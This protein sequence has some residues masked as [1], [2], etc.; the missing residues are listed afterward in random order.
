MTTQGFGL[1]TWDEQTQ[2]PQQSRQNDTKRL[3]FVKLE[4]GNNILRIITAPAKYWFAK[5]DDGKS[6]YGRRVRCAFP[7]VPRNECPTVMAG[8]KPKKRYYAGVIQRNASGDDEVKIFDMSVVVYEKLQSFNS[9]PEYG[10]PDLFDINVRYNPESSTPTDFYSVIPRSK[11]PLSEADLALINSVG[12][13]F[14]NE[15]L[16]HLS[17]PH[18]VERVEQSLIKLGWDGTVKVQSISK[19]ETK[20]EEKDELDT[21][22]DYSFENPVAV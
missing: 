8:A 19:T 20:S 10:T 12:I 9:D 14:I 3:D 6:P 5:Y 1:T 11:K 15:Q 18:S 7:A 2:K 21:E 13:D 4:K 22:A 16:T 17:T